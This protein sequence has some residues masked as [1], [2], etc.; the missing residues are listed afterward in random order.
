M[1][2]YCFFNLHRGLFYEKTSNEFD[3]YVRNVPIKEVEDILNRE[4][5]DVDGWASSWMCVVAINL[6]SAIL[7]AERESYVRKGIEPWNVTK[8]YWDFVCEYETKSSAPFYG[9]VTYNLTGTKNTK[10]VFSDP[11]TKKGSEELKYRVV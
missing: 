2:N 7:I 11:D 5:G 1:K 3:K 8:H 9:G 6:D 4:G 10:R